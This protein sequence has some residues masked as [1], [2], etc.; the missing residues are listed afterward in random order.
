MLFVTSVR[1]HRAAKEAEK[2]E[3][4]GLP[5]PNATQSCKTDSQIIQQLSQGYNKNKVPG[6]GVEIEVEVWV[7]LE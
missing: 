2:S 5:F 3:L 1:V 7:S 4:L 6:N